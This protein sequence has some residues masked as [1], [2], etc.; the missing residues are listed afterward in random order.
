MTKDDEFRQLF[1]VSDGDLETVRAYGKR[2]TPYVDVFLDRI[3]EYLRASLGD[4]FSVHFPDTLTI[5]RAK[6]AQRAAWVEFWKAPWDSAYI[7]SREHVGNVHAQLQV[8]PRHYMGTMAHAYR[9]WTE[10]LSPEGLTEHERRSLLSSL[11]RVM[12]MEA[13][14]V[15]DTYSRRTAEV[16]NQQS[17][18]LL[19]MSTPIVA[20][21]DGVLMLPLVG[22][23]DS[24]RAQDTM[25]RML[26]EVAERQAVA[27][28]LDIS[29]VAVVDTAVANHLIRMT[30]ATKLM[31]CETIVSGVSPQVAETIVELGIEIFDMKTTGNMKDALKLAFRLAGADARAN[32]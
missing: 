24:R 22:I 5:D 6:S 28:I 19:D 13:A 27:F 7:A 11:Q 17:R 14:L 21:S 10:E 18:A 3:Y 2:V 25:R 1:G 16:I 15:V 23:L 20:P 31:G 30:K 29:G 4:Y 32:A 9:L 8:E 12:A 26:Q